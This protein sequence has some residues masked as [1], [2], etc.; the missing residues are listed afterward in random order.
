MV[1]F[2]EAHLRQILSAYTTYYNQVRTHLALQKDAPLRRRFCESGAIVAIPI[3]AGLHHQYSDVIFG[4][5]RDLKRGLDLLARTDRRTTSQYVELLLID[6]VRALLKN[7]F[8]DDGSLTSKDPH[9]AL[10]LLT[11]NAVE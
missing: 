9:E 3:L 7:A 11:D 6:H 5:D 10:I 4:R 2:G 1:I 8:E